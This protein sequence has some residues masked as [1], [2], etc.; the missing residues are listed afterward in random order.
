M[1]AA[2]S[3]KPMPTPSP[4]PI[5]APMRTSP[6]TRPAPAPSAVPQR[7]PAGM[8]TEP[9]NGNPFGGACVLSFTMS[10]LARVGGAF[11]ALLDDELAL[12]RL[13]QLFV[14]VHGAVRGRHDG[15][16]IVGLLGERRGADVGLDPHHL[17]VDFER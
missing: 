9:H 10:P 14:L 17:H 13:A 5:K 3:A 11:S 4:A 16:K 1:A 7:R 2:N 15:L 8:A 6:N 12:G